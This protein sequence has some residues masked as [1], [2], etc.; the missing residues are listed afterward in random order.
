MPGAHPADAE[1][2]EWDEGNESELAAHQISPEEVEG[3]WWNGPVFVP[4]VK[5]KEGDWKMIG[6]TEGGRRLTVI[7]RY[8]AGRRTVRPITGWLATP[9]E[10]SKY[11]KES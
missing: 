7:I 5:H 2:W 3:V 11:L 6:A 1:A 10:R 8:D 9:G 4:N